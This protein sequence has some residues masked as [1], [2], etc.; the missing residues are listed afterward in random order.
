M[1]MTSYT[2]FKALYQKARE[3]IMRKQEGQAVGIPSLGL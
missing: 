2:G 1:D 3:V